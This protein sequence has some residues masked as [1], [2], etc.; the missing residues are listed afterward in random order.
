LEHESRFKEDDSESKGNAS[1][2]EDRVSR[3]SDSG[4]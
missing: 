1:F 2:A 4:Y 3:S